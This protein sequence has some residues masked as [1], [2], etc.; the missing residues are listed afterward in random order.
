[1]KKTA[2]RSVGLAGALATGI[3]LTACTSG[4]LPSAD[5]PVEIDFWGWAPGY[6]EA[7]DAYNASQDAVTVNYEEVASGAKGGYEKMLNAVTA[8]NAPCLAQVGYETLTSFAAQGALED[9]SEIAAADEDEFSPATWSAMSVGDAVFGAPVDQGPMA[10]FYNTEV[11]E[12]LGLAVPT[13]WDEYKAAAE[14]IHAADPSKFISATYLNYDYAGFDWQAEAPWFGVEGDAWDVSIDSPEG[15][16]VASYWQGMVDEGLMSPAPMWDQSW[17]TGIGDGSIATHVGAV[18]IAGVLKGSAPDGAGK[19][20]VAPMPQWN[21]GD[22]VTGNVGGSGTA[23][24]KGCENPE[25]AWDFA[26]FMSTDPDTFSALV[27]TAGLYPAATELL[28]LPVLSEG[29]DY[30]GGQKIYEVFAESFAQVANGWVWGP[31]MPET[32]GYLDDAL[33]KAW[34]GDGT[35]ADALVATQEKTVAGLDAQ[36]LSVAE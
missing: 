18:W 19:W 14:T 4:G 28:S 7:V 33:S 23:V 6:A 11:F 9:V 36:G 5:A 35:I 31:T 32:V 13:T 27:T 3:A 12:S 22:E 15:E 1:M 16:Q 30:F 29:D 34:A 8:G 2:L 17:Y 26:H 10:M 21:A 25:A 24:L 20:A